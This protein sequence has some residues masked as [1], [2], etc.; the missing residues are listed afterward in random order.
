MGSLKGRCDLCQTS[1]ESQPLSAG[2]RIQPPTRHLLSAAGA[3][4]FGSQLGLQSASR[5]RPVCTAAPVPVE[6]SAGG[7]HAPSLGVCSPGLG[8]TWVEAF[9]GLALH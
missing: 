6:N 9:P 5:R 7:G 4:V 8:E 1:C 2:A 3:T